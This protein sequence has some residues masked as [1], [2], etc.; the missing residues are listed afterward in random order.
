M[1]IV[2]DMD[3]LFVR[4]SSVGSLLNI[5]YPLTKWGIFDQ[6]WPNDGA[7]RWGF[8]SKI[9][10]KN[11]MPHICPG[12]PPLG[13]NIDRCISIRVLFCFDFASLEAGSPLSHASER[14]RAKRSAV[15][16]EP[17]FLSLRFWACVFELRTVV[18]QPR[19][20]LKHFRFVSPARDSTKRIQHAKC[21]QS[22][23]MFENIDHKSINM[24]LLWK[25][26]E[27]CSGWSYK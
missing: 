3:S 6:I 17:A 22:I 20:Q 26:H 5:F 24:Q 9:L 23:L 10:L 14:R 18:P 19:I 4:E 27:L 7:P 16:F 8:W 25:S 11:Q 15:V 12:S 1:W 21:L 2:D 13:L